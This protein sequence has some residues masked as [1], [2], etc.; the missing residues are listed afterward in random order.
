MSLYPDTRL[1]SCGV[2]VQLGDGDLG[3]VPEAVSLSV[4]ST[5][6]KIGGPWKI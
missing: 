1:G 2:R 4:S 5:C 6:D 3:A